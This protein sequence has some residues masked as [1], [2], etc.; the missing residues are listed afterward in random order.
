MAGQSKMALVSSFFSDL[1][2]LRYSTDLIMKKLFA[3]F[4]FY[5]IQFHMPL[6]D[7]FQNGVKNQD[8]VFLLFI[9]L[10]PRA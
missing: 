4:Q 5:S 9:F 2:N 8:G 7:I 1:Q 6:R 3:N 10:R